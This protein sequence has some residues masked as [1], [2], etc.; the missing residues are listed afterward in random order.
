MIEA[1]RFKLGLFVIIGFCL[2]IVAL[3][4]LGVSEIF[5][6]KASIVTLFQESVQGLDVGSAV[7]YKGVPIGKVTRISIR[8]KDKL[9]RVDMEIRLNAFDT[10]S[11]FSSVAE[12]YH[13]FYGY[14]R[15]EIK[16]GLRC[17]LNYA[18]ITGLKYIEID[19]FKNAPVEVKNPPKLTGDSFYLP[20]TPSIFK[21]ILRLINKSLDKIFSIPFNEMSEE[22][23]E[24]FASAKKLLSDPKITQT[25]A[26]L[27][28][29]SDHLESSIETVDKALTERKIKQIINDLIQSI[30]SINQLATQAKNALKLAEIP[31]TSARFREASSAVADTKRSLTNT[32]EKLDQTLDAITELVNSLDNDPSSIIRGK[33][34]KETMKEVIK[35]EDKRKENQ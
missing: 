16:D 35:L 11:N 24:T 19:Y 13:F 25:I 1:N 9:I 3:F 2:F 14:F 7:K 20:S 18:G 6:K 12:A 10:N 30:S 22:L 5:Q 26:K 29:A 31:Q 8:T 34:A 27:E 15:K 21:D 23:S 4:L 33:S 32:L 28:R 17:Q